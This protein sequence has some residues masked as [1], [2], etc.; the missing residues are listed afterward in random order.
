MYL[1]RKKRLVG[2]REWAERCAAREEEEI[3]MPVMGRRKESKYGERDTLRKRELGEGNE[4]G[5]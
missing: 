5:W 3:G 1:D 4:V 2:M